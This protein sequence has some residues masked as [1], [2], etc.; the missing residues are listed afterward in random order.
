MIQEVE[1]RQAV[2]VA[3]R[4]A[5]MTHQGMEHALVPPIQAIWGGL[6]IL[7]TIISTILE[8]GVIPATLSAL[9]GALLL[10]RS[11]DTALGG[12]ASQSATLMTLA[13]QSLLE[14]HEQMKEEIKRLGE[15]GH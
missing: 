6:E 8:W 2:E 14:G 12:D 11:L 7:A 10:L 5:A 4:L 3:N 15:A 1:R 13:M 9:E